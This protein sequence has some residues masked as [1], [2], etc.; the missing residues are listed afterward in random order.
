MLSEGINEQLLP[1]VLAEGWESH[2]TAVPAG[3]IPTPYDPR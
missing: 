3:N 1:R 2:G